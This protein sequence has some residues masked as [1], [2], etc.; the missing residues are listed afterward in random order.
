MNPPSVQPQPSRADCI[1]A[2]LERRDPGR[3]VYAPNYWQW[4]TH[5]QNHGLL[6]ESLRGC[7]SQLD[8]IRHLGLDVF[9]R[10]VYCDPT[11]YWFGGLAE[12]VWDGVDVEIVRR[13]EGRDI[14]TEKTYRTKAG[15]LTERLR[16]IFAESTLVQE[17]TV[18]DDFDT[19]FAA[20]E[21]CLQGRRWRFNATAF[22]QWQQRVG[23]DGLIVAGELFSPLKMLHLT[24]GLTGAVFLL[25]DHPERCTEWLRVHEEAQ[26]DL[27]RQMLGAGVRAMMA[28]D[29]LDSAFHP[30]RYIERCSARFYEQASRLCREAGA[31]FFIHA[32]G[33][34]RAILPLIGSLGVDGLEG[35]AYPTL[36]N[37]EL[38]EAMRLSGE[39]LIITGGIS[40]METER[41]KTYEEVRGY[42]AGLF[43]RLR[44]YRHRFMLSASCNTSIRTPWAV[45][46]WFRD[47]WRELGGGNEK[48]A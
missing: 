14:V 34:Q 4:F 46:E 23:D 26:L 16:Y 32:C 48:Q 13:E 40:A 19:Q 27:V 15:T 37:V 8:M 25:E 35:V 29:N 5:H 28:V 36:G 45:I 41:F 3:V 44:P 6:P 1:R 11:R 43:Q 24:A 18:L 47:A 31:V 42:L 17:K 2:V 22:E 30:P 9:S 38:E 33:Q 7:G 39:R 12:E 20:F 21:A 10:N